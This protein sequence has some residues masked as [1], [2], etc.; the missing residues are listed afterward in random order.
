MST[1]D[2][3]PVGLSMREDRDQTQAGAR[4]VMDGGAHVLGH[5]TARCH[6]R[7]PNVTEIGEQI[8]VARLSDVAHP[9]LGSA[10]A[11]LGDI[12]HERARL[13]LRLTRLPGH[14]GQSADPGVADFRPCRRGG[15]PPQY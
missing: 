6:P 14:G 10:A 15:C 3:W 12:T 8:A 1:A 7:E 2:P 4:L 11:E 5:G 13:H 9:L